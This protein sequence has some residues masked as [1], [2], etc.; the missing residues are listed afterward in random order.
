M[1]VTQ[2]SGCDVR[3]IRVRLLTAAVL[4]KGLSDQETLCFSL[5][6]RNF[7]DSYQLVLEKSHIAIVWSK[8]IRLNNVSDSLTDHI[9]A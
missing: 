8:N 5:L 6:F 7:E 9:W 3:Y 1:Q 2:G 4:C